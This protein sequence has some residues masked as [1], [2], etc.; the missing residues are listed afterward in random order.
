MAVK[1]CVNF[2]HTILHQYSLHPGKELGRV[3]DFVRGGADEQ[4]RCYHTDRRMHLLAQVPLAQS[5]RGHCSV[6]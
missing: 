2:H 5:P 3:E 4:A 6:C 1:N